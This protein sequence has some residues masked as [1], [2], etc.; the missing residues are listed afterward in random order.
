MAGLFSAGKY[1]TGT[2]SGPTVNTNVT[3]TRRHVDLTSYLGGVQGGV[4]WILVGAAT[5]SS[6]DYFKLTAYEFHAR[7]QRA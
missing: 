6:N 3:G 5:N 7:Q 4:N 1:A 2:I